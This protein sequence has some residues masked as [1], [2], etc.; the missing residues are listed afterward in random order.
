MKNAD[1]L[2]PSLR[3]RQKRRDKR[4]HEEL[5]ECYRVGGRWQ[6]NKRK[7]YDK[8]HANNPDNYRKKEGIKLRSGGTKCQTDN[9]QPLLRF[10]AKNEG[11]F[12]NKVYQQLCQ[13]MDKNSVLGQHVFD[14]ISDFVH[15][16]VSIEN[17]KILSVGKWG[18]QN[19]LTSFWHPVFYVHPKSGQ[20]L[21]VKNKRII[22]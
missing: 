12:W 4:M 8:S 14:H 11:K 2:K 21:K 6:G 15:T 13:R 16:K 18:G 9:L 5:I 19:E 7:G 1:T 17:G 10:L 22:I 3:K 20:L